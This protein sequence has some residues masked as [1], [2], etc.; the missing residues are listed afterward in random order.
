[1]TGR[2]I[3]AKWLIFVVVLCGGFFLINFFIKRDFASYAEVSG[4]LWPAMI[5]G[6]IMAVLAY[7]IFIRY[8]DFNNSNDVMCLLSPLLI[9]AGI[10]FMTFLIVNGLDISNNW[11]VL[12]T[13][14]CG[15][16]YILC[17]FSF[18]NVAKTRQWMNT[19][20]HTPPSY[21]C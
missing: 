5:Q 21:R 12:Y 13:T 14:T 10:L 8:V 16:M 7:L 20:W 4:L 11:G 17:L 6:V 19:G 3:L 18:H 1:M 15:V 9:T 2:K